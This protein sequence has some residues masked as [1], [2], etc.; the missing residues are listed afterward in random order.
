MQNQPPVVVIGAGRWGKN[1]VRNFYELS[2]LAGIVEVNPSLCQMMGELYPE[3]PIYQKIPDSQALNYQAL[4]IATP[5]PTHYDIARSALLLGKDVF[6]EKPMTLEP[7]QAEELAELADQRGLILMVG[8]LLLYQPA[9]LWLKEYIHSG[10]LG[11]IQHIATQRANLGTVRTTENAL[12]SLGVHDLAVI[13]YLLEHP[14]ITDLSVQGDYFLNSGQADNVHLHLRFANGCSAH[15]H[16]SWF[17]HDRCR[18]TIVLGTHKMVLYDEIQ[19]QVKVYHQFIDEAL[20]PHKEGIETV[21]IAHA[22]PLRLE[23]A[24]FLE[25]VARRTRP[26]ADGWHGAAVVAVLAQAQQQLHMLGEK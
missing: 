15:L 17:W 4:V 5:A 9:I 11:T 25:C 21:D 2:A 8:H 19:Q 6:V 3:I 18:Q 23:C 13:L 26:R 10:R 12:W 7:R 22:E 16:T 14:A 20:A 1:L 24:H